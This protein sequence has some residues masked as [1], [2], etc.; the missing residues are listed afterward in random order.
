MIPIELRTQG[1]FAIEILSLARRF[2][3]FSCGEK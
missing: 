2:N 1:S 3:V